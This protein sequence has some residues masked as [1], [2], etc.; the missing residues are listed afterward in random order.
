MAVIID[1]ADAV[2]AQLNGTTFSQP[3]IAERHYQ[4]RFELSEMTEL[5]LSV[6]VELLVI[7]NTDDTLSVEEARTSV[8]IE[9]CTPVPP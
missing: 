8:T 6:V 9:S 2:V 5:K 3:L 7:T 4:P 1:I